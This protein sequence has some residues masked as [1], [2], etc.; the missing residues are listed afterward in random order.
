MAFLDNSGDIILDAVLTDIGRKRMAQGNFKITKCAYGD[1]EIDYSLYNK[2]A[3]DSTEDLQI[4]KTPGFEAFTGV[5]ANINYGLLSYARRDLL[6]LPTVKVNNVLS[7]ALFRKNNIYHVAVNG[8]TATKLWDAANSSGDIASSAGTRY[9]MQSNAPLGTKI[10]VESGLDTDMLTKDMSTR[11]SYITSLGL[12]DNTYTLSVNNK[13]FSDALTV[14]P[15]A[16]FTN[17]SDGTA[18]VNWGTLKPTGISSTTTSLIN[19][20]NLSIM[21][22]P[23]LAVE[24]TSGTVSV[25]STSVIAGPGGSAT[26]FNLKVHSGLTTTSAGGRDS[27]WSLDGT[28][29]HNV[30]GGS[31]LY[32]YIDSTVY[33]E[34]DVSSARIQVP[35]RIIRY[36][37][38]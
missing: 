33:L 2:D 14:G 23:N 18:N 10:I 20:S 35:V 32:D 34:G 12:L 6:Y 13:Y 30:F 1:D 5:N 11:S 36:A 31:N 7:E 24:R 15:G 25:S 37:G 3:T 4:F 8:E 9:F 29:N 38:T 22:V 27:K 26:A 16:K 28:I 19:Y 17:D 21:A